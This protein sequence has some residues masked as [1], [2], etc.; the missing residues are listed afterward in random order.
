[1]FISSLKDLPRSL[2]RRRRIPAK[3]SSRVSVVRIKDHIIAYENVMSRHQTFI[4]RENTAFRAI[5]AIVGE[6]VPPFAPLRRGK[7]LPGQEAII[8]VLNSCRST[9]NYHFK[10]GS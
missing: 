9:I 3:S 8:G 5:R 10:P 7:Q 1:M 6:A 4:A 2:D